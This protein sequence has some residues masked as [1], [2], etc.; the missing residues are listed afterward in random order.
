M[1]NDKFKIT[2]LKCENE[3]IYI[4]ES[5]NYDWNGYDEF[6]YVDGYILECSKCGNRSD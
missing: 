1:V 5:I 6:P 4:K 3:D 2:C